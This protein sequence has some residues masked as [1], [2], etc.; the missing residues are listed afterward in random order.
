MT[1]CLEWALI[2]ASKG[3]E[4]FPGVPS[5]KKSHKSM[6]FSKGVAWGKTT[7]E[8]QII[9]DWQRWPQANVCIVTGPVSNIFVLDVDTPEGHGPER[10]GGAALAAL[11]AIHGPLPPTREARSPT[12]GRHLYFRYPK[13][14]NIFNS[15]NEVGPGLD[16]RGDGGMVLAPPSIKPAKGDKPEGMYTWVNDIPMVQAPDWLLQ[17]ALDKNTEPREAGEEQKSIDYIVAALMIIPND[18]STGW[19]HWNTV[20]MATYNASGHSED[21]FI[22]FDAWSKKNRKKYNAEDVKERW[23]EK[24]R[25]TPPTNIGFGKLYHLAKQ[26]CG[27]DWMMQFEYD[28]EADAA[29][30]LSQACQPSDNEENPSAAGTSGNPPPEQPTDEPPPF[31]DDY[32]AQLLGDKHQRALRYV[33]PWGKWFMYDKIKWEYDEKLKTFSL[34]RMT[35]RQAAATINKPKERKM[36]ASAKTINAVLTIARTDPRIAASVDQWDSDPWLL[37]TPGGTIDLRTGKMREHH[38]ADYMTKITGVTPNAK[39]PIPIWRKFLKSSLGDPELEGYIQRMLGYALT[40]VTTEHA[41][42]FLYG[43]GR[44]GKGV[45]MNTVAGIMLDYHMTA[46]QETFVVSNNERHPTDMAMLRGAR[47]VTVSETEQGK[48][49]AES[50]IKMMTGGDPITARFMRQDFFTYMPQFK[51]MMSGQH[52]PGLNSVNEAMRSRVNML[53]FNIVIARE[54]RDTNLTDKLKAEW[55]GI[56]AWMIEGCLEWQRDGLKP[57]K[58]VTDATEEYMQAQDKMGRWIDECFERDEGEDKKTGKKVWT[59]SNEIFESWKVWAET[60]GEF[61]GSQT[62]LSNDLSERGFQSERRTFYDKDKHQTKIMGFLGLRL[63]PIKYPGQI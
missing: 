48:R 18:E 36:I 12:G 13:N 44:N 56:L 30:K 54:D 3:V 33:S 52:K 39:C 40:G 11:E 4:V 28:K 42:F 46:T 61:P 57:P 14:G 50:R 62:K 51:L 38:A 8:T 31:S 24:Y 1:S 16:I 47:L 2:Y 5:T 53:P 25:T 63:K 60:N 15:D 41:L 23:Y 55:P 21:G 19:D 20:G 35:C 26:A 34:S 6:K 45:L 9:S 10:D 29:I 43:M 37:N 32:L 58:I 17:L 22:A 49:W 27:Q 59:S 7:N